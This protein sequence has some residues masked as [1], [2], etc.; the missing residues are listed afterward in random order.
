MA[1]VAFDKHAEFSEKYLD[2]MRKGLKELWAKGPCKEA[3]EISE[4][5]K[6]TR[7]D[8][9]AWVTKDTRESLFPFEQALRMIGINQSLF[10]DMPA[11]SE[12]SA[13]VA[14]AH[15]LFSQVMEFAKDTPEKD[16]GVSKVIEKIQDLLGIN[17][18]T[19]LRK[20]VIKGANKALESMA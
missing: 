12:R 8:Y 20:Q 7:L 15:D 14:E 13:M 3:L 18:L 16:I 9:A 5:L 4:K 6:E 19:K 10:R 17:E 1:I 2:V 11:G